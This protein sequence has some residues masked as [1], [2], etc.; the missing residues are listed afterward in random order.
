MAA[1]ILSDI[2]VAVHLLWAA[3]MVGGFV[4]GLAAIRFRRLRRLLILRTIHL[5]GIIFTASVPLWAGICPVTRW[6]NL[7]RLRAGAEAIPRSFLAYYADRILYLDVPAWA[8]TA[9]TALVAVGSVV[10]YFV[11]PPWKK[12]GRV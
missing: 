11:F 9:G 4:L 3:F 5:A 10:L 6:E 1:N 8:I 12:S 2:L 7:L